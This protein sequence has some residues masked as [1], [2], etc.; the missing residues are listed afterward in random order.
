MN[1]AF[2]TLLVLLLH[3]LDVSNEGLFLCL[4]FGLILLILDLLEPILNLLLLLLKLLLSH[5]E[6]MLSIDDD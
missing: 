5:L 4:P 6:A 1:K 2:T 3:M